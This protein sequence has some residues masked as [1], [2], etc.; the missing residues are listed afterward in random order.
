MLAKRLPSFLLVL[1]LGSFWGCSKGPPN[2]PS[3]TS[4]F[5]S[6]PNIEK[7]VSGQEHIKEEPSTLNKK[8]EFAGNPI[9]EIKTDEPSLPADLEPA[10]LANGLLTPIVTTSSRIFT[11]L[12]LEINW[13]SGGVNSSAEFKV[14]LESLPPEDAEIVE[15]TSKETSFE[16][17]TLANGEYKL[18]IAEKNSA[19]EWGEPALVYFTRNHRTSYRD[20]IAR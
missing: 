20:F 11:E 15:Y 8:D 7:S 12:K 6:D 4:Q 14:R 10:E 18:S 1:A 2:L 5:K 17:T 13:I 19:G 3:S 16:S 9:E